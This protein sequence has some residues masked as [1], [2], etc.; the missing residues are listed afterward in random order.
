MKSEAHTNDPAAL[1]YRLRDAINA[2]D[3]DGITRCFAEDFH[4][5]LPA[6]PERSFTGREHVRKNWQGLLAAIPDLQAE[7]VRLTVDGTTVWTEWEQKGSMPS[8]G[9]HLVRG[10]FV[11][12]VRDGLARWNR[13]YMNPVESKATKPPGSRDAD[14]AQET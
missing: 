3:L 6:T 12:D 2:H 1:I 14:P 5:E 7:V 8:G 4:S 9:E 11:M 13:F 10:M